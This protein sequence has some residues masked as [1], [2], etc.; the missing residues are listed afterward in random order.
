MWLTRDDPARP[1]GVFRFKSFAKEIALGTGVGL[2]YDLS[3]IVVRFDVGF[4]LHT[5]YETSKKG[6]YN[7]EKFGNARGY[8]FAIGYPF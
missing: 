5:P 6:Y 4:G 2:R 1:G 8:H 7:I 3:F